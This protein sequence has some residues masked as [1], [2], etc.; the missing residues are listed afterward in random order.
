M[1]A[2]GLVQRTVHSYDGTPLYFTVEGSGPVDFLLA[3]GIG[4][5]GFIWRYLEPELRARGRIIHLHMRGH[6]KSGPPV[7]PQRVE[8][9]DLA[10]D[11][12]VVLD[13]VGA[14]RGVALGHSMGVQVSLELWHRHPERVSGL[15]LFCGSFENPI[16]TFHDGPHAA[17]LLP[18][19]Q[20]ITKA[21]GRRLAR[22]WRRTVSLPIAYHFARATELDPDLA[23]RDDMERYLDHL[24]R[25]DPALFTRMLKGAADHSAAGYLGDID[26]PVLVVAGSKDRFTPPRLSVEMADRI[27]TGETL[28]V[29]DG[30]HTAPIEQPVRVNLSVAAFLDRHFGQV[31]P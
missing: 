24:S 5:D 8:I 23:R 9:T 4:C 3:D 19:M 6:G 16:A 17:R 15:L 28:V 27:P 1:N 12:E 22:L 30:T 7:D 29:E 26:V 25:M 11:W 13:A 21:G 18:L 14:E 20:R 31:G 10:D 2:P